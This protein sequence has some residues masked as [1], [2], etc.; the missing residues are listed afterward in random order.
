MNH[1]IKLTLSDVRFSVMPTVATGQR[2]SN[3]DCGQAIYMGAH[4]ISQS[5]RL[6]GKLHNHFT[7]LVFCQ[8]C[9]AVAEDSLK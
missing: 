7:G 4:K 9:A 1:E 2:C 3:E 5:F 6:N 8:S